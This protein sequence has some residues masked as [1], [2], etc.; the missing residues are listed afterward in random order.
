VVVRKIKGKILF[1]QIGIVCLEYKLQHFYGQ[2]LKL[3][4]C[5]DELWMYKINRSALFCRINFK[6]D[7]VE[8]IVLPVEEQ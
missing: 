2:S 3:C 4:K 1:C 7:K 5:E 8:V 6:A